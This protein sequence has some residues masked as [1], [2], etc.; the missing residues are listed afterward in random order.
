[1][2]R[3]SAFRKM[4]VA[5]ACCV[6]A[7]AA[8]TDDDAD[9][10]T[11]LPDGKYPMAFTAG[12]DGL[13]AT[14]A[15]TDNTWTGGEEVAVQIGSEVKKYTAATNNT[16]SA[17]EGVTPWYWQN[18]TETKTVSAWYPY[19]DTKPAANELKV[20][21]N[22]SGNG[23]G[24]SDHL[25]AAEATVTFR[26]PALTFKHRTAK[27]VVTLKGG[28]GV[29]DVSSATVWF[30]N[31][32]GVESGG[33]EITP[34]TVTT[35]GTATYT[36]LLIPQQMQNQK[37]I[38][39]TVGGNDYFYTPTGQNDANLMGGNQYTYDIT[40]TK[41]GL[42]VTADGATEWN[43][44]STTD[45]TS[46]EL[47]S[48]YSA[49]DLKIG[50]YYYSD[51]KWSDGGYRKY[52]DNTTAILPVMPVLTNA[53]GN[54]RTVIGIVFYVGD[55]KGDNYGLLDSKFPDGTQG[56]VVSLWD[57]PAPDNGNNTMTWTYGGYDWV[58]NWLDSKS[59]VT[60]TWT[61]RPSGFTS[62]QV[63][64]KMQGYANTVALEEYNKYVEGKSES[65]YGPE[66][67]KRVKPVKGLATFQSAHPAPASSS[68]WYWHSVY[69]LKQV[70]WG[71]VTE[72]STSGK[73]MLNTQIGKAGGTVFPGGQ[74]DGYWASTERAGYFGDRAWAV[75]FDGGNVHDFGIKYSYTYRVR[76]L[77]AF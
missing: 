43:S 49:S 6:F 31:Q 64:D 36:A 7:F 57:M 56:L 37:F 71:G 2:K 45:V 52:G 35:D 27:V 12:V 40:V 62:V 11:T 38:K 14:R 32:T 15:T 76:P 17:A 26:S 10:G 5:A 44:S 47:A 55:I 67:D 58:N 53:D 29:A 50:D 13:A 28:N 41:N 65:G 73:S 72:R 46:K 16:L 66:G 23:Y 69:E 61:G 75:D 30:L 39:V 42:T 74:G 4:T 9:D 63:T 21:A 20:K 60:C 18:T 19:S 77:L 24:Q 48:G 54:P 1:M 70:C 51:G 68:G 3:L 59:G 25:E 34:K 8:C 22:Q 33:T